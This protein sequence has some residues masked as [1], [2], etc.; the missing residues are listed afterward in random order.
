MSSRFLDIEPRPFPSPLWMYLLLLELTQN[1]RRLSRETS[2]FITY[3]P[4]RRTAFAMW[5]TEVDVKHWSQTRDF[6]S[7]RT[8]QR[9][10]ADGPVQ[11]RRVQQNKSHRRRP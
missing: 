10:P 4:K 2:A 1:A 8:A 6:P 5:N 3:S 11:V 9:L 7:L